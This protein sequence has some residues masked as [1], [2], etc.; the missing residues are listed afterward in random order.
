MRARFFRSSKKHSS[1]TSVSEKSSDA[2][3]RRDHRVRHRR[4]DAALVALQREDRHVR[5]DDDQHREQRRP[6]DFGR[7]LED[8]SACTRRRRSVRVPRSASR[9][10]TF[11][12]HDHRAIHD[13]AEIHRA[14]RKQ[15]GG[16]AAQ[17]QAEERAEQRER[18]DERDDARRRGNCPGTDTAR[19]Y[20]SIAPS[21]RLLNTV[22]SV[23][24]ISQVRS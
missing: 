14:E 16:N 21:T 11:S 18:N 3:Q 10:N 19:A 9:R 22:C 23:V 15:V 12:T 4:E 5:R 13:D 20:T 7:R 2:D 8:R 6:P 24:S 17:V 1:G